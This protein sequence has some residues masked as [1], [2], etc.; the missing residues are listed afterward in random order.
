M[1]III[2]NT[3]FI[4]KRRGFAMKNAVH[5]KGI[6]QNRGQGDNNTD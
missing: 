1:V 6:E 3:L 4:G 5:K 2:L